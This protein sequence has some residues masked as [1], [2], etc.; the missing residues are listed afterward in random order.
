MTLERFK[1]FHR[2]RDN[3]PDPRLSLFSSPS[4]WC[5]EQLLRQTIY[6]ACPFM[7]FPT[8][9]ANR[10]PSATTLPVELKPPQSGVPLHH[11][12]PFLL[13]R[14]MLRPRSNKLVAWMWVAVMNEVAVVLVGLDRRMG[15]HRWRWSGST[16]RG[17]VDI[18][19]HDH[20][21]VEY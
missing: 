11:L 19:R 5:L 20:P 17:P 7:P 18:Q 15:K 2:C 13:A 16:S 8:H 12:Q 9:W 6:A 3:D 14:E 21:Q 4:R 1:F 10:S